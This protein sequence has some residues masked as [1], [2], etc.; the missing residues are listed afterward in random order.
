MS[1]ANPAR[2]S[3]FDGSLHE[4]GGEKRQRDRHIDLTNA[5]FV[6]CGNLLDAGEVDAAYLR[7]PSSATAACRS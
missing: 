2:Q 4:F 7:F 6:A 3:S 1:D 5:A